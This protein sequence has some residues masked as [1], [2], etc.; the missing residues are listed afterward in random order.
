MYGHTYNSAKVGGAHTPKLQSEITEQAKEYSAICHVHLGLF[1]E[2]N[3]P[4]DKGDSDIEV[5]TEVR[6]S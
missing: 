6:T 1:Q 5:P 4:E 2:R 3:D